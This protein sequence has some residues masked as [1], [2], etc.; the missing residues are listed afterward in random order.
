MWT[1]I[2]RA[3]STSYIAAVKGMAVLKYVHQ[4]ALDFFPDLPIN[5][6][7]K[8]QLDPVYLAQFYDS[9]R[10]EG[11]T[12]EN[13]EEDVWPDLKDKIINHGTTK[14]K[15]DINLKF[16]HDRVP[17]AQYPHREIEYFMVFHFLYL[18]LL[19]QLPDL[20]DVFESSIV[21]VSDCP[22][23]YDNDAFRKFDENFSPAIPDVTRCSKITRDFDKLLCSLE[24]RYEQVTY[25][26]QVV[27]ESLQL[28]YTI[29]R[30]PNHQLSQF[31]LKRLGWNDGSPDKNINKRWPF[32][33]LHKKHLKEYKAY[34][35]LEVLNEALELV[36]IRFYSRLS[37]DITR[38]YNKIV[39][40]SPIPN[41]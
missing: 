17:P 37:D 12:E 35:Y 39:V 2:R 40:T 33:F 10:N 21:S 1:N 14:D 36:D 25:N 28:Q 5:C 3:L 8:H 29:R 20:K 31:I 18:P 23:Y 4:K 7:N 13:F 30:R 27:L 41:D 16:G 32:Y 6:V 15:K 19:S 24:L 26:C 9:V 22:D 11:F 38:I 34:E